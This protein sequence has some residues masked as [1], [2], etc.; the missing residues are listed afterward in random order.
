ML[1]SSETPP[2]LSTKNVVHLM[3]Q[4]DRDVYGDGGDA[5]GTSTGQK[6]RRSTT[7]HR[8]CSQRDSQKFA[9]P[10]ASSEQPQLQQAQ[11]E[12]QTQSIQ[13]QQR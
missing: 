7:A 11:P 10:A 5:S 9:F 4:A 3:D 13:E 6:R 8:N 12:V 2:I 1:P